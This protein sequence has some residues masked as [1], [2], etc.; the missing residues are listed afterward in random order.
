[1]RKLQAEQASAREQALVNAIEDANSKAQT[2]DTPTTP[3][4]TFVPGAVEELSNPDGAAWFEQRKK[5]IE[6]EKRAEELAN[7]LAEEQRKKLFGKQ[8]LSDEER[9]NAFS[10]KH[11]YVFRWRSSNF[12]DLTDTGNAQIFAQKYRNRLRHIKTVARSNTLAW[13]KWDGKVWQPDSGQYYAQEFAEMMLSEAQNYYRDAPKEMDERGK[14]KPIDPD[15]MNYLKWAIH[16]R[17]SGGVN[18]MLAM[19]ENMMNIEAGEFDTDPWTLNTPAGIVDLKTGT[20]RPHDP[21]ALCSKMTKCAPTQEGGELFVQCLDEWT[22]GD[23]SE[24]DFLQVI[25]GVCLIG[26]ATSEC[27]ILA[28]GTGGNGKSTFF[29][30][31]LRALGDYGTT[32]DADL[33]MDDYRGNVGAQ[34]ATLRGVRMVTCGETEPGKRISIARLKR[35]ASNDPMRGEVKYEMPFTFVPSH[36]ICMYNNTLPII[37]A[38]D[39]GTWRRIVVI[40]FN[41]PRFEGAEKDA[42]L[43]EKLL[44][45]CGGYILQWAID[46][47]RRFYEAGEN[48]E[49][50][51]PACIKAAIEKY[52]YE[53]DA[54]DEF[55]EECCTPD[56]DGKT[57]AKDLYKA[58]AEWAT[59][60]NVEYVLRMAE[61]NARIRE[62]DY[63][64]TKP[65]N[66]L[67]W[68]GIRFKTD[69]EKRGVIPW[70][71][72]TIKN[73]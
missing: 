43:A 41:A 32:I 23:E 14:L 28:T 18:A 2:S 19:A 10:F 33:L 12:D 54:V 26:K 25:A 11:H 15:V 21:A 8:R 73:D 13:R 68:S 52:R 50:L 17:N 53:R 37:Q 3:A 7:Q 70:D 69:D 35:L 60:A 9:Y 66:V 20:L 58:Y 48:I 42:Q 4:Q 64:C 27:I 46:G 62:K 72:G 51:M 63:R 22:C 38:R 71:G 49:Q 34:M 1:M 57:K 24:A 55:L 5:L 30:T 65:Q 47:A 39:E 36:T 40:P 31:I 45:E 59:S 29:N 6:A 61:F 44:D 16:T 67:T 56:T